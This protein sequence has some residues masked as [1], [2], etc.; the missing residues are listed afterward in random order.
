MRKREELAHELLLG[1]PGPKG[2]VYLEPNSKREI[3]AR[4]LLARLMRQEAPHGFYTQLVAAH[5]CPPARSLFIKRK[6]VFQ[7]G[8]GTPAIVADRQRVEIA[9]FM[10]EQLRSQNLKRAI[11]AAE[12]RF[13]R[14]RS[15]ILKIWSDFQPPK[16]RA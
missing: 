3:L 2:R 14:R 1:T 15:T 10:R 4:K 6:I 8:K 5:I 7:R 9:A 16:T 12:N 11:A 13:G